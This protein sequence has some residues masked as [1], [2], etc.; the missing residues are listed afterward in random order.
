MDMDFCIN[1]LG[2][3]LHKYPNLEIFNTDQ[4]SQFTAKRF[5]DVLQG[6]DI[7]ISMDT[8]GA[9]KDNVYWRS[10]KYEC[11][12]LGILQTAGKQGRI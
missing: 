10:L 2:G 9:W 11:V 12:Y 1:A 7:Q 3:A 4:G 5:T 6:S 8:K